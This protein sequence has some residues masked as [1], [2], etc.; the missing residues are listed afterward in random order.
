MRTLLLLLALAL[1]PSAITAA[2]RRETI[3]DFDRIR[4][5]GSFDVQV[6]TGRGTSLVLA[7]TP[8]A[9]DATLV[10]VNGRMLTI[11]RRTSG[12][13]ER[14]I[15][16][17][18]IRITVPALYDAQLLGSG[19]LRVDRMRGARASIGVAGSGAISV[20]SIVADRGDITLQGS[21]RLVA[22]GT[23]ASLH[24]ANQ[25]SGTL[26]TSAV[27]AADLVAVATG[28]GSTALAARRSA[29][30]T[31]TGSGSVTVA[32]NPACTVT[33]TGSGTVTCGADKPRR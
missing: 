14:N 24:A 23:I 18:T 13:T 22:G 2:E 25:G 6:A 16:T 26:D 29:R 8:A 11:R 21:G 4:V 27:A 10:A 20:G 5:E 9:I 17:T 3:T 19:S 15:G 33:S 32:G 12:W 7:G 28:S 31:A 30:I 1:L